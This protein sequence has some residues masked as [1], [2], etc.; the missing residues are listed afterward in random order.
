MD[1]TVK[2]SPK[3]FL[4]PLFQG[5]APSVKSDTGFRRCHVSLQKRDGF[6]SAEQ[7]KAVFHEPS[8]VKRLKSYFFL[9]LR[10]F[11]NGLYFLGKQK[12]QYRLYF[13]KG[14]PPQNRPAQF[15]NVLSLF[16]VK[17]VPVPSH[18]GLINVKPKKRL[19]TQIEIAH[20]FRLEL[21]IDEFVNQVFA[22]DSL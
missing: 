7:I 18:A 20:R 22:S 12:T 11:Y 17:A 3:M 2:S 14:F 19:H 9:V 10:C 13:P 1:S 6:L 8:R 15:G 4:L 16:Q 21:I 5:T